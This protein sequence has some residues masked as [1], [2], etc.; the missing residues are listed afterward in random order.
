[1][2][3]NPMDDMVKQL[4]AE[5]ERLRMEKGADAAASAITPEVSAALEKL[6]RSLAEA[7][8]APV[9]GQQPAGGTAQTAE[10]KK[11]H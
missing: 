8:P 9:A 3:T 1:M 6:A 7:K 4:A 10:H 11:T 5:A 2:S